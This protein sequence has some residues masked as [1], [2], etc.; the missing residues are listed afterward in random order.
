MKHSAEAAA[1]APWRYWQGR[2][3]E[4]CNLK[5]AIQRRRTRAAAP[6]NRDGLEQVTVFGRKDAYKL[7]KSGLPKLAVPLIDVPQSINTIS[8]QEMQDRAVM[9]LNRALK[10]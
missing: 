10:T 2:G 4:D 8:A 6:P 3:T 5:E 9:A 7:D 1:C